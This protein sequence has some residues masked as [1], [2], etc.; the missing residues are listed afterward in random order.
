MPNSDRHQDIAGLHA[1][2]DDE[3][4]RLAALHQGRLHCRPGCTTCCVDDLTIGAA[5]ADCIRAAYPE[6]LASG[7]PHPFGACACLN[8]AGACRVYAQRPYV[9]RTQGLPL[10]WL[11]G[12]DG[13]VVE[14]RDI[15]PLN[16]TGAPITS[17]AD[18]HCWTIGPVEQRLAA[19]NS[20]RSRVKIRDLFGHAAHVSRQ[21]EVS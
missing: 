6:L 15:C 7:R 13:D 3:A 14:H 4:A 9:C 21:E 12:A 5:E 17:L 20:G 16:D 10:R 18:T 11:E 1:D 2:I 19:M 8:E